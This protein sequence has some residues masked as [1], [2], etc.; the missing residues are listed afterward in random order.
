MNQYVFKLY[1]TGR[2]SKSE[3]AILNLHRICDRW[4]EG[5]CRIT[6]IDVL[7]QPDEAERDHIMATPTL[8]KLY[9]PPVQRIIGDLS[10][11]EKVRTNLGFSVA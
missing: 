8:I 10:D 3:V 5:N 6:V 1:V 11:L 7:E 4:F 9:P 2:T